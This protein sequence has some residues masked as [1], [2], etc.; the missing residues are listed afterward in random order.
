MDR[1]RHRCDQGLQEVCSAPLI[2]LLVQLNTGKF[3]RAIDSHEQ[4]EL[5]LF[6]TD[7][8]DVDVEIADWVS[9]EARSLGLVTVDIW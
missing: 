6:R 1:V 7:L 2:G 4:V 3:T 5:A 9:L 8:R